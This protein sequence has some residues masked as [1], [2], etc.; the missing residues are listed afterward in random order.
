T[1]AAYSSLNL[2]SDLLF[3]GDPLSE[4]Q[5]QAEFALAFSQK[6]RF[7]IIIDGNTGQLA[8]IRTLRGLTPKFGCFDSGEIEELPFERHLAGN[9]ALAT[10]EC[11]YWV[12]KMQARYFAGDCEEAMKASSQAQPLLWSSSGFFEEAEYHF[13]SALSRAACC[14]GASADERRQHLAAMAAHQRQLDIWAENCPE[15]FENRAAL[16]RAEIARIERRDLDAMSLY[17]GAIRS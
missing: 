3:A 4:V 1:F 8:L 16:V 12:R 17:E 15:N 9:P 6:A 14:D 2:N 7:G 5:R 10:A 13:Y 11:W